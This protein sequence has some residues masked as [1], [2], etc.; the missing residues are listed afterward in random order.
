MTWDSGGVGGVR[1][2]GS[3]Y[4][5][6]QMTFMCSEWVEGENPLVLAESAA[7]WDQKC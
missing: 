2:Q 7:R 1:G 5:A 3:P 4:T 6:T